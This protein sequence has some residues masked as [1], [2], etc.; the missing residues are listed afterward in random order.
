MIMTTN[1]TMIQ[2]QKNKAGMTGGIFGAYDSLLFLF[3]CHINHKQATIGGAIV[4]Y[5]ANLLFEGSH[6]RTKP[7]II[8][9]NIATGGS[10]AI[11]AQNSNITTTNGYFIF[12]NNNMTNYV[13]IFLF[14]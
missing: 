3:Q 12:R 11:Y 14:E 2:F 10:G 8:E 4:L 9:N 13:R 6:D 1:G 5:N 7:T